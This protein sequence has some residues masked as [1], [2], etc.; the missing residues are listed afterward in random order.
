MSG[1]DKLNASCVVFPY[2]SFNDLAPGD[3][4]VNHFA[5]VETKFGKRIRVEIDNGYLL[6][7]GRCIRRVDKATINELNKTPKHM[8]YSGKDHGQKDRLIISFNDV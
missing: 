4:I 5:V 7:P 2:I 6:L 1:V 8:T 3:Y